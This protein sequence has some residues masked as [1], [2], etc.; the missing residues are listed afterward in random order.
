MKSFAA[1]PKIESVLEKTATNFYANVL[2]KVYITKFYDMDFFF[3]SNCQCF[4][5]AF[6]SPNF[7]CKKLVKNL[8]ESFYQSVHYKVTWDF[9]CKI[10]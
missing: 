7:Y 1:S 3:S 2:V 4:E 6:F 9:T 10:F 8:C 5:L